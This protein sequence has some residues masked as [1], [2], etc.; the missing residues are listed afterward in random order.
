MMTVP[1][2]CRAA[3]PVV[4]MRAVSERRKPCLVRVE[5]GHQ[6]DLGQ[7]QALAQQVDAHDHVVAAQ[8]QIAQDLDALERL[9][10][11]VQI[12][13]LDAQLRR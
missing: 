7:V 13:D 2:M 12:V 4:W 6:A 8:P 5:D 10:L 1:L 9:D 11:A 3:R